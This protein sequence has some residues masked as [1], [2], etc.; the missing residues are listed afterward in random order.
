MYSSF[1]DSDIIVASPLGLRTIIG[2]EGDDNITGNAGDNQI[3][4]GGGSDVLSGG[5]GNDTLIGQGGDIVSFGDTDTPVIDITS[6]ETDTLLGGA[7][8]DDLIST[9]GNVL[10][11]G[12]GSDV[13][14][15]RDT[16]G[17]DDA[18]DQFP[19]TV[20]TDFDPAQ[21]VVVLGQVGQVMPEPG[22]IVVRLMADGTGSEVL[23]GGDVIAQII[24][25]QTLTAN[26]IMIEDI[27]GNTDYRAA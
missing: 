25:G 22:D 23:V 27:T 6:V 15:V 19:P 14:I 4:G 9:N 11:G 10:T 18:D 13:F 8:D 16:L 17:S 5:S 1:Y 2:S 3:A 12:D 24:G 20:I 26:D 7:G 21:D